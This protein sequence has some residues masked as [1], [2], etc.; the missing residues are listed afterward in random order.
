MDELKT[1]TA[2]VSKS[3][4]SHPPTVSVPHTTEKAMV[5]SSSVNTKGK[6]NYVLFENH[7]N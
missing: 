4:Q 7:V 5:K 2:V 1:S 3:S 6:F